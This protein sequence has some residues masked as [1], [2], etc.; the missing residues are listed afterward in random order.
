MK[1]DLWNDPARAEKV[2][3][4]KRRLERE[5]A[6]WERLASRVSD[7]GVLLELAVE[8]GAPPA[9]L[10]EAAEEIQAA[11]RELEGVELAR[12]L[13]GE[14]DADN[15]ILTIKPGA[16]GTDSADWS[17]MLMRMYVRWAEARGYRVLITHLQEA[18][19]AGVRHVTL[20]ISGDMPYGYLK[21]EH[22][23]HRLVRI[24]PFDAS[25]RR[26]TSFANV[27]VFPE[28]DDSIE[29]E[30]DDSELRI[31]T[32]RASGAGGQHV[33]K[34]D[35]AVRM[36]HLPTGIVVQCQNERSQHKNKAQ[37]RKELRSRLYDLERREQEKQRARLAGEKRAIDFG[38]QMRSYT[39]HPEKRVKDHLT[40]CEVGDA[41]RVLD[42]DID[43][44]I[45]ASL[46]GRVA[47]AARSEQGR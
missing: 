32:Y 8:E 42:G 15:V 9:A 20:V 6:V 28:I 34:T 21:G 39:L 13:S 29:V 12:M 47:S 14:H 33:N 36:T 41:Q 19:E 7:A 37:A 25:A 44:F 40:G 23:V 31:D 22:G 45:R 27:E 24:S 43:P 1:P 18:E 30:I 35:S 38:S 17:E 3:R 5:L 46:L 2:L 4:E 16:G 26:H 11:E 10:A